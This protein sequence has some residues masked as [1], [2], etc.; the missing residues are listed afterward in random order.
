MILFSAASFVFDFIIFLSLF[1][2]RLLISSLVR[3]SSRSSL[4]HSTLEVAA[5]ELSCLLVIF[6]IFVNAP[7]AP[8]L[9]TLGPQLN[10]TLAVFNGN[11]GVN[12][13]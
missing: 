2:L 8:V 4:N 13:Y 5:F 3:L 6:L 9:V 10:P 7:A 1:L 12:C 11:T